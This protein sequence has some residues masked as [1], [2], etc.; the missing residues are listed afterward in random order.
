M[1]HL[2]GHRLMVR[3]VC[4]VLVSWKESLLMMRGDWG[5]IQAE[6]PSPDWLSMGDMAASTEVDKGGNT[7]MVSLGARQQLHESSCS[8]VSRMF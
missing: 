1:G 2:G 6:H 3:P 8:P 4:Q 7:H 5:V